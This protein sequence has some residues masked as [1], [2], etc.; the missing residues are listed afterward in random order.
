MLKKLNVNN[1][2]IVKDLE[3]E[4][5]K[6]MTTFTGE[7][8]SGKSV[9]ISAIN[10]L[11][12]G[13]FDNDC[14]FDK[15]NIVRI[16]AEFDI[17]NNLAAKSYLDEFGFSNFDKELEDICFIRREVS[18]DGRSSCFI[19]N[20][21]CSIKNVKD[22][23]LNL[24]EIHSQN[25]NSN[26]ISEKKQ[27][28]II[29][30]MC[31]EPSNKAHFE[32]LYSLTKEHN[33]LLSEL[34]SLLLEREKENN[35]RQLKEYRL[36][37]FQKIDIKEGEFEE[38]NE[39]ANLINSAFEV[40]SDLNNMQNI[41]NEDEMS[42]NNLIYKLEKIANSLPETFNG[43]E[44][45]FSF[46]ENI[47]INASEM[48]SFIADQCSS[49]EDVDVNEMGF[50]NERLSSIL[51]LSNRNLKKPEELFDYYQELLEDFNDSNIDERIE[52][53][54]S[55][56]LKIKNDWLEVAKIVSSIRTSK[57]EEFS[58]NVTAALNEL[59]MK[60]AVFDAK[61]I[62]YDDFFDINSGENSQLP[63]YGINRIS[64]F[65]QTNIG[66]SFKP[67]ENVASGGEISRINLAI[68]SIISKHRNSSTII[69]D[70]ID[71][72]VG[73]DVA[74][75]M[76]VYIKKTSL[77]SQV[78]CISHLAQVVAF[79]DS[80]YKLEKS[81]SGGKTISQI[82]LLEESSIVKELRRLLVGDDFIQDKTTFDTA[83]TLYNESRKMFF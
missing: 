23:S 20:I 54:E 38:L 34:N 83:N 55:R 81:V 44:D 45:L 76:G 80:F 82:K 49:Y 27:M 48:S 18:V 7:S 33:S 46:I 11:L 15:E 68:V 17:S 14:F 6:G 24:I 9:V 42:V 25:Q 74:R 31:L 2:I 8:G 77:H 26:L 16:S 43:S 73:G 39:K 47:K 50:I 72:G 37:E 62:S 57:A 19:N 56:L 61:I 32:N 1:F 64:F 36:K 3:I 79:S 66:S 52:E 40:L 69:F 67:I 30:K 59:H 13:K 29:D 78:F 12:G 28:E 71:T 65:I 51:S 58:R 63:Y 4:P 53:I 10:V 22:L 70:E 41:L 5:T 75:S 35:E 21:R 60:H